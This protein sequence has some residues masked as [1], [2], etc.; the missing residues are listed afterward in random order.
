MFFP[1]VL[2]LALTSVLD[3]GGWWDSH[4]NHG[5]GLSKEFSVQAQTIF[6][7]LGLIADCDGNP[8]P[9]PKASFT[10]ISRTGG[11]EVFSE[12]LKDIYTPRWNSTVTTGGT[13]HDIFSESAGGYVEDS[14]Y[15]YADD[16]GVVWCH[17][18]CRYEPDGNGICEEVD[19]G[20]YTE[21]LIG[22]ISPLAT[23]L[24]HASMPLSASASSSTGGST[25]PVARTTSLP[26]TA[27]SGSGALHSAHKTSKI[28]EIVGG[29]VTALA[30]VLGSILWA[31]MLRLRRRRQRL[32]E[33][34]SPFDERGQETTTEVSGG[35]RILRLLPPTGVEQAAV[36]S[37]P[38][39][40][41]KLSQPHRRPFGLPRP[42][43]AG[44][45][46]RG[47]SDGGMTDSDPAWVVQ[48]RAVVER[49]ALV[50]ERLRR[51]RQE[52]SEGP[53]EYTTT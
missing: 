35:R 45:S 33:S 30:V 10:L 22:T 4:V 51:D 36:E 5:A 28:P 39:A 52:S 25:L 3:R 44:S 19:Q 13:Y 40:M 43:W 53:P 14:Y 42:G 6:T 50:E 11:I 27:T 12:E 24:A 49:V 15:A 48:M 20:P 1:L 9:S 17:I 7:V 46:A 31:F 2:S 23:F 34:L 47:G 26:T 29:A 37:Q 18:S 38:E 32:L 16:E 8:T 21:T 41:R